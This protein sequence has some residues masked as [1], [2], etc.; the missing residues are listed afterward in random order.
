[1]VSDKSLALSSADTVGDVVADFASKEHQLRLVHD[2]LNRRQDSQTRRLGSIET[3]SGVLIASAAIVAT[4]FAAGVP[5]WW[6]TVAMVFSLA[7]AVFGVASLFPRS[8]EELEP[9]VFR[10]SILEADQMG[11]YLWIIDHKVAHVERRERVIQVRFR[12]VQFGL[13]CL[14]AAILATVFSALKLVITI[15]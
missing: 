2:E 1:V 15:G 6:T 7:A 14:L 13:V 4:L 11:G 12:L 3:V 8:I 9:T 10:Q 5:A